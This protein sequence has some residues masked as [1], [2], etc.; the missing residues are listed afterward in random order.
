MISFPKSIEQA[1]ASPGE[2][3]AGGTDLQ[4]RRHLGL[5]TGDLVDLRDVPDLAGITADA[6][7]LH[8]GA[9][10]TLAALAAD[11]GVQAGFPGIA[12][13]AGGLA[14]PQIRSRATLAGS[15]LQEVRCWYYRNPRLQ[16]LK[17]GGSACMA[18]QGDHLFHAAW[19]LGPCVAPHPSTM[20]VALWAY[21]AQVELS[22]GARRD[23]PSLLGTGAD[24]RQTHALAPGELL[25]A[26]H[27]PTVLAGERAAYGRA[28]SRARAEWPLAEAVVR[29]RIGRKNKI[30]LARV[31]VGGVANRPLDMGAVAEAL[32]GLEATDEVLAAA[33]AKAAEGASPLPMTAYKVKLLPGLLRSLLIQARDGAPSAALPPT[34]AL[35]R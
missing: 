8:L 7:E 4:E 3:R 13:A 18:R 24:P 22:T 31:V 5:A 29:L 15:L 20:A 17:K 12:A 35:P 27:V 9:G 16:C 2:V 21:D 10:L 25:K 6:V 19:D 11:P 34:P 14:T 30:E 26:V 32:L 33:A 23:I 28:I 1:A